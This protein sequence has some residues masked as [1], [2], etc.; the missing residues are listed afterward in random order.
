MTGRQLRVR[1]AV[2]FTALTALVGLWYFL[3]HAIP[4]WGLAL[5]VGL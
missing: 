5:V 1:S 3:V 2:R 4:T